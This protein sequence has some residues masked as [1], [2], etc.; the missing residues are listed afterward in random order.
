MIKFT[1]WDDRPEFARWKTEVQVV[2]EADDF[3]HHVLWG[4]WSKGGTQF[5]RRTDGRAHQNPNDAVIESA[6]N[7]DRVTWQQGRMGTM[8]Q[9]GRPLSGA[10]TS[11]LLTCVSL[12]VDILEGVSVL[13]YWATSLL[14]DHA[15][16]RNFIEDTFVNARGRHH[17]ANNF[18]NAIL[19]IRRINKER[20]G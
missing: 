4:Q 6:Y 9:V 13:F 7:P 8:A 2:V 15:A 14:V 18:H 19:D 1:P 11:N 5:W 10:S 16:T 3:A 20:L 17:D 12:N